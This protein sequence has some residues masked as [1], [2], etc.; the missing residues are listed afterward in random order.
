MRFTFP[1]SPFYFLFFLERRW[2]KEEIP[3]SEDVSQNAFKVIESLF[4]EHEFKDVSF[5]FFFIRTFLNS[6]K[7]EHLMELLFVS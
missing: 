5:F 7:R 2:S 3:V 1:S 6:L 4:F